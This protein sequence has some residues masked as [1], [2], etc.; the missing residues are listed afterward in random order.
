MYCYAIITRS[1]RFSDKVILVHE[2]YFSFLRHFYLFSF[3]TAAEYERRRE[4]FFNEIEI[5]FA[6]VVWKLLS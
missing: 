3:Q 2:F 6:D 1:L 4:N 5:V